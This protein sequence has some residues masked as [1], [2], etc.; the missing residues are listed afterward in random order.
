VKFYYVYLL[1]SEI[2][3]KFYIGCANNLFER[4]KEHNEGKVLSTKGRKPLKLIY[5]EAIP[6]KKDAFT[7]EKYL[8]T[9]W[10]KRQLK[11]VLANTLGCISLS[12]NLI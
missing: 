3:G 12:N 1:L 2:D 9:G 5:F 6:N 11:I 10:G 8:K 7:R 4:I